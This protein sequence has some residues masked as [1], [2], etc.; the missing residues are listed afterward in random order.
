VAEE[1]LVKRLYQSLI[2]LEIETELPSA[3]TM[4]EKADLELT[5][6][7]NRGELRT[8]RLE[9]IPYDQDFYALFKN[10]TLEFLTSRQQ[11]QKVLRASV[12]S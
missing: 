4:G 6:T 12:T 11:V 5:Y 1:L 3:Q 7:L 10:G 2:G 8:Y 9:Y